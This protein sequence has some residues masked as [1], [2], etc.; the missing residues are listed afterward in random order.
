MK[1]SDSNKKV[2][3]LFLAILILVGVFPMNV[4]AS[5]LGGNNSL[6]QEPTPTDYGPLKNVTHT[7]NFG[8]GTR[9]PL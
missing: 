2:L 6:R 4:L 1:I 9:S 5:G 3:S 7:L 8:R